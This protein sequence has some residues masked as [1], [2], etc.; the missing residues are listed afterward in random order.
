M[1]LFANYETLCTLPMSI[2]KLLAPSILIL[3]DFYP[4]QP[5]PFIA[6]GA[7]SIY[8]SVFRVNIYLLKIN[9]IHLIVIF[10]KHDWNEFAKV[11]HR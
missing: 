5:V 2:P 11:L 1:Q 8:D 6:L 7:K 4:I 10:L 9:Q 3:R